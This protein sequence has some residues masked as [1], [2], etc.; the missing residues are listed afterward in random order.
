MLTF[1]ITVLGSYSELNI[2]S[3][4]GMGVGSVCYQ[5]VKVC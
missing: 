3:C 2:D 1:D 5:Y 4:M